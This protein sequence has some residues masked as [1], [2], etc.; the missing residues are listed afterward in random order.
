VAKNRVLETKAQQRAGKPINS[1]TFEPF[2]YP[3]VS[4]FHPFP[5]FLVEDRKESTTSP[6]RNDIN[7]DMLIGLSESS[8]SGL[9]SEV[10]LIRDNQGRE[11]V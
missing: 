11:T 6:P 9:F 10:S 3:I 1:C 4:K 2:R 7:L 5:V 8:L